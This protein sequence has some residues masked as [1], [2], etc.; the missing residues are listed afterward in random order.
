LLN[1]PAGV[2]RAISRLR[3]TKSESS[4]RAN[5]LHR[6]SIGMARGLTAR[7]VALAHLAQLAPRPAG[8]LRPITLRRALAVRLASERM[9]PIIAAIVVLGASLVSFQPAAA[10]H[11]IGSVEGNGAAPRLAVGGATS[12]QLDPME[13]AAIGATGAGSAYDLAAPLQSYTDDG[14]I[15]KPVAVKTSVQDAKGLLETYTVQ[16][17]DTL[18]GIASHYGLSMMTLWWANKL[19][20]K[21][22]LHIGQRLVIPP[23][24]GL[25][26]TVKEGDT[27]DSVAAQYSVDAAGILAVNQLTE[28]NL[29]IGQT[30]VLP[31]AKGAPIPTPT[32]APV[33]KA[34]THRASS[35]CSSCGPSTFSGG[36]FAWPVI[37]GGN[38]VSQ[39]FHYGH[40]AIDI[41]ADYGSPVVA[42]ADGTVIFAGWKNNGG[43]YQVWMSHGSNLYTTYNHMSAITVSAGESVGRG[44]QVGR[45]GQSGD[46][47][48][49]HCHFEVWVGPIWNGG[50]RVNPLRYF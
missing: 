44:Q 31:D 4:E 8:R 15:Y 27:L 36:A 2:V 13:L 26:V 22:E 29:I 21:D 49:P 10:A 41:A 40:Y 7:F 30:L 3:P 45:V 11:P 25:V 47:T 43:G 5:R 28:S 20:T 18:T 38:Y 42:A 17:G 35:S 33:K 48:G 6:R 1:A 46:A 14:T 23:V 50:T 16:S 32:P 24:N 19:T 12:D 37:G 39:G 9:L 34:A